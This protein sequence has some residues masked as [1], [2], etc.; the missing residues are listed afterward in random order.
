MCKLIQKKLDDKQERIYKEEK[1]TS[2]LNKIM[3]EL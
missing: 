3:E 2:I 1:I